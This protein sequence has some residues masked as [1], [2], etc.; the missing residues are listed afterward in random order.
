MCPFKFFIFPPD[1]LLE[2]SVWK[3]SLWTIWLS[4]WGIVTRMVT[5]GPGW[6]WCFVLVARARLQ[7]T[8]FY[9]GFG[10][11]LLKCTSETH[12]LPRNPFIPPCQLSRVSETW[13]INQLLIGDQVSTYYV[14]CHSEDSLFFQIWRNYSGQGFKW[15]KEETERGWHTSNQHIYP[16]SLFLPPSLSLPFP[17]PFPLPSLKSKLSGQCKKDSQTDS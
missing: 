1:E 13:V 17:S 11:E 16:N 3:A 8:C 15:E 4:T 6:A 5:G 14:A 10:G 9:L 12:C 2:K 7:P